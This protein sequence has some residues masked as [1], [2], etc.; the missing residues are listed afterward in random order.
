[1]LIIIRR[2]ENGEHLIV[3]I[4][5]E[6]SILS[7][8]WRW[9]HTK[10]A[11]CDVVALWP[12]SKEKNLEVYSF[13]APCSMPMSMSQL[14]RRSTR[15]H[16]IPIDTKMQDQ[17]NSLWALEF[18]ACVIKWQFYIVTQN[19]N[20]IFVCV[21]HSPRLRVCVCVSLQKHTHTHSKQKKN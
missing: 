11:Q 1:M 17:Y 4:C 9:G 6:S 15:S 10:W 19:L 21:A 20:Y 3:R 12:S 14:V 18:C 16:S 2:I 5:T 13:L 8:D 7:A